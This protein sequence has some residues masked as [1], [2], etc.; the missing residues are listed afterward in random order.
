[1]IKRLLSFLER[2]VNSSFR[3]YE[4][5]I[6]SR[7]MKIKGIGKKISKIIKG[8]IHTIVSCLFG[9]PSC[10]KDYI[11]SGGFYISKRFLV[12]IVLF[13]VVSFVIVSKIIVPYLEGRLWAATVLVNSSKYHNFSGK[14]E[15]VNRK[16]DIIYIGSIENGVV[17]GSG[18]VYQYEQLV[19]KGEMKDNQYH[20]YGSLYEKDSL[21]YEGNF[22]HNKYEGE[23]RLYD[24]KGKLVFEG[25]FADGQKSEGIEYYPNGTVKYKG[26]Y[27]QNEYEGTGKLYSSVLKDSLIYEGGFQ[28]GRYE[29]EGKLYSNGRLLYNGGFLKGFYSGEGILYLT[30]TGNQL[31]KGG[32]RDG[33]YSGSGKLLDEKS[34]KTIY[35]GDFLE[36]Q[37]EGKGK[38]YEPDT[39]RVV[40]EGMFQKGLYN[41][42]GILYGNSGSAIYQGSFFKGDIDYTAFF[43]TEINSIREAFGKESELYMQENSFILFYNAFNIA[44]EFRY[45]END[46][47]PISTRILFFGNQMI[48]NIQNGVPITNV[49]TDRKEEAFTE[50]E[51]EVF[52]E[53]LLYFQLAKSEI[54]IGDTA[55]SIKYIMDTYYIRLYASS[56]TGKICYFEI[57]GI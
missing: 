55:Y 25:I 4:N 9:K 42:I 13:C 16:G 44:F 19:Y 3:I 54:A 12:Y 17:S 29:G 56:S 41:G 28:K 43:D 36:G 49:I 6:K 40:Y 21:L 34:G 38:L 31:Y 45:V 10:A 24:E 7:L 33:L 37:Y 8:F 35:E 2:S 23:G 1:M 26:T 30:K 27:A 14:A 20:G 32:F 50:Y 47:I 57:G 5:N 51:F 46:E 52:E 53:D 39:G 22:V 18:E 11:K 15:V 48:Q